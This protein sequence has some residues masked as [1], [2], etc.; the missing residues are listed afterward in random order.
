MNPPRKPGQIPVVVAIWNEMTPYRLHFLKRMAAE[1]P[2]VRLV[3]VFTHSVAENSMPWEISL[4]GDIDVRF[5]EPARIRGEL[6]YFHRHCF[7]LRDWVLTVVDREAPT[8]VL[9]AGHS[10]FTRMLLV[11]PLR[12]RSVPILHMSDAN[13]FG[14]AR[15]GMIKGA[16]RCAYHA[17]ILRRFDG[18]VTMGTCGRAYYGL[19][20]GGGRPTFLSPYEPDYA[21]I[22]RPDAEADSRIARLMPLNPDR[23]RFLY[24]G[25]LVGWKRVD[26]LVKAFVEVADRLPNWDLVVAGGGPDMAA[27]QSMVPEAMRGRV[28]FTGFLQ[29]GEVRSCYRACH[30]LVHPSNWEPWAL[31]I[32][33]AVAAGMAI[34]ATHVTGAAVELVRH[35]V[36]G[37]L[38]RPDSQLDLSDALL[39]LGDEATMQQMRRTSGAVLAEWRNA[40]DPVQGIVRAAKYFADRSGRQRARP[41]DH[42]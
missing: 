25:R 22:E 32:N 31:V 20:G 6:T 8:L 26:L 11:G 4:P 5:N 33:E 38:V 10:D 42:P 36:N 1:C 2:E 41:A 16:L 27:L 21:S 12:R 30:V 14:L 29:M 13:V 39:Q 40:A 18:Y 17:L 34:V 24:S 7:A 28:V 37:L 23:R 35:R 9:M 15:G 19:L 3:N